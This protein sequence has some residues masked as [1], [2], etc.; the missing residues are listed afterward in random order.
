MNINICT[1]FDK[2]YLTKFL[3][4][5]SSINNFEKN[6]KF[7]CLCLDDFSIDYLSNKNFSNLKIISLNEI[8]TYFPELKIA[9]N[10]RDLIEFYFTLSPFLPLYI[11]QKFKIEN[12]NYIDCDL[13]FF[14]TP[15]KIFNLLGDKSI[16]IVEH[17]IKDERF[18]K[19]NVGWLTFRNDR[20]ALKCLNDW[21][22][23]CINWCYDYVDGERYADQKYLDKWP[24][25]YDG[26]IVLP[27]KYCVGPW[28][29]N[30]KDISLKNDKLYISNN[31]LIFYH[32]HAL[33]IYKNLYST[34]LSIY[35]K[36]LPNRYVN[37]LYKKYLTQLLELDKITK[38]SKKKIRN[39]NK[40][41]FS[42][43]SL[44][45]SIKILFRY[46]KILI[47]FDIYKI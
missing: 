3:A 37:L 40:K 16:M 32:F 18:G 8:E 20:N 17:G 13:F 2:N 5:K 45:K 30:T 4:C 23:N 6:V 24:N 11:L 26:V 33:S 39:Q 35:N 25:N 31:E 7:Y 46:I 22:K 10:N 29:L 28:N 43:K 27:S 34:G 42:K 9:K 19:Y 12:I 41:K 36:R 14:D 38:I 44:L 21:S 47:F 1:Y 15:K